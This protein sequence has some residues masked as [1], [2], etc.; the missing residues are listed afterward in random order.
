MA[1]ILSTII[2]DVERSLFESIRLILVEH[3]YLPDITQFTDDDAGVLA[4]N[5]AIQTVI[6]NKGFCIELFGSSSSQ[7][8]YEKK[9]PRMVILPKRF[10][11]G[12][13]GSGPEA[14][15]EPTLDN[16]FT[17]LRQADRT[18]EYQYEIA[19]ISNSAKQ[20][21]I[22][23]SVL[24]VAIPSRGYVNFYKPYDPQEFF[25]EQYSYRESPDTTSGI[26]EKFYMYRAPDIFERGEQSTGEI[27]TPIN[28]INIDTI[29]DNNGKTL[30]TNSIQP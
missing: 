14:L 2:E 19:L 16:K 4:W 28:T 12:D 7:K 27:I 9:I 1:T 6:A 5:T 8:K 11:P 26:N 15:Y 13:L 10:I 24:K 21:R 22:M 20:D 17:K 25:V 18:S 3:G 29:N 30:D 23:H